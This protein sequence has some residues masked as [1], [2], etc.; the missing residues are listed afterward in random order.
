MR[1]VLVAV[2]TFVGMICNIITV[3]LSVIIGVLPYYVLRFLRLKKAGERWLRWIGILL[4]RGVIFFMW[5]GVHVEGL[6]YLPKG[7][8]KI[9]IM[10][11]H[12]GFWDIPALFGYLP[13]S[14]GFVA[15]HTLAKI[16]LVGTWCKALRCV[17]IDRKNARS[18]IAAIKQ[19]VKSIEEGYPIAIFPEGTRSQSTQKMGEFRAGSM[20]LATRSGALIVP[21]SI[22][23]TAAIWEERKI[24]QSRKIHM[25]IHAPIDSSQYEK[26][27]DLATHVAN[28]IT[29]GWEDM[30]QQHV[31]KR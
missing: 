28:T 25:R 21:V 14:F 24:R 26:D 23:G 12:Q 3:V 7:T 27:G 29:Q 8:S 10:S 30:R 5:T 9:C 4:A 1:N 19:G 13:I 18:S 16:P 2:G 17:F 11:N 6:E 15:K 22:Y 31:T 20:K